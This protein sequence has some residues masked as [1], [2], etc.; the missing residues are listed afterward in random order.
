MTGQCSCTVKEQNPGLDLLIAHDW[1]ATAEKLA[2]RFGAEEGNEG[3]LGAAG[4]FPQLMIPAGQAT[5]KSPE[6]GAATAD[7]TV[8][9]SRRGDG[10]PTRRPRSLRPRLLLRAATRNAGAN[11]PPA[12]G[13]GG[14][15]AGRRQTRGRARSRGAR[16]R[17]SPAVPSA[18]SSV[19]VVGGGI[20][21]ALVLLFGLTFFILRPR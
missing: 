8:P 6:A 20:A 11:G 21:V 1:P 18:L 19:F 2:E 9:A 14:D 10:D 5:A 7:K 12:R 16:P 4:L 15:S 3:Q 17:I 13:S